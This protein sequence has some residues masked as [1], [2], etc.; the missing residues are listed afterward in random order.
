M[1]SR[2]DGQDLPVPCESCSNPAIRDAFELCILTW[3]FTSRPLRIEGATDTLFEGFV[4]SAP[5]NITTPSGGTHLCDGTNNNA[6][7]APVVTPTDMLRDAGALCGFDFDGTYN[8]QF[9]DFFI[10]RIANSAQTA[11]QFW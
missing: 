4:L 9:Q 1:D 8:N 3:L 10:S 7:P 6:N 11:T 2:P 5:Q